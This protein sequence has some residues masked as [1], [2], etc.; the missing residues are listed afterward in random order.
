MPAAVAEVSVDVP[1][2]AGEVA[3]LSVLHSAAVIA[4]CS[5]V[6]A[7]ETGSDAEAE[8]AV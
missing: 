2:H 5:G 1:H 6:P 4:L 8:T 7:G 3:C